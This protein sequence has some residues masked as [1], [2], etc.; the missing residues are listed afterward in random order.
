[1]KRVG[2]G[3]KQTKKFSTNEIMKAFIVTGYF[4]G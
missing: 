1:M 4:G 3:S 2:K